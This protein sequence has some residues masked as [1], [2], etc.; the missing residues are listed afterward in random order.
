MKLTHLVIAAL[1]ALSGTL[2]FG[3]VQPVAAQIDENS[4]KQAVC[5]G[6][7]TEGEDCDT[8]GA[9]STIEGVIETVVNILSWIIGIVSVI[10]IIIGGFKYVT[11]NG[12]AN[13]ISSAKSTILYAI[14]GLVIAALAQAIVQFVLGNAT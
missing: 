7:N 2:F 6:L 3:A 11:S 9:S 14:V 13:A 5:D 8:A 10:M 1:V 4:A 12:D